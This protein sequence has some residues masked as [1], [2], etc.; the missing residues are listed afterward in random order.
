MTILAV[1]KDTIPTMDNKQKDKAMV[2]DEESRF[3]FSI[4]LWFRSFDWMTG[5]KIHFHY[6]FSYIVAIFFNRFRKS[7]CRPNIGNILM[8]DKTKHLVRTY[9]SKLPN[10]FG[11][12]R[13]NLP[14]L[15]SAWYWI[16][17]SNQKKEI[18]TLPEPNSTQFTRLWRY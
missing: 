15:H 10:V 12:I 18:N 7:E 3:L 4:F 11:F 14:L 5:G 16:R 2:A 6:F 8:V 9:H 17:F 13:S 1:V